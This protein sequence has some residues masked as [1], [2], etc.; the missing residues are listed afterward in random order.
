MMKHP[1][2][3]A[4]LL[5]SVARTI[6]L[7]GLGIGHLARAANLPSAWQRAQQFEVAAPG[8]VKLSLPIETL[9]ASRPGLEDLRLHDDAGTELPYWIQIPAPAPQVIQR[10]KGFQ[11]ALNPTSTTVT[12]ETGLAQAIDGVLLESPSTDFIKSVRV[13]SSSDG[14]SWQPLAQGVPIFRQ[15]RGANQ[16]Q[17]PIP[18]GIRPWLRLTVDDQRS[19]PIP[20][21]GASLHAA[22]G[23]PAPSEVLPITLSERHENPGESRLTLNLGAGNA[24][25]ASIQIE[26][27]DPLFIRRVTL[28]VSEVLEDSVRETSL[29]RGVIYRV[30]VEGQAAAEELSIPLEKQVRS[31]QLLVLIDNQDSPPLSITRVRAL[32][33]P[34]YLIFQAR[35][36]GV[37]HLVTGNP[38]CPPARYDLAALGGNL[39]ATALSSIRF[40]AVTTNSSFHPPEALPGVQSEGST[41]DVAA[42]RFRKAVKL[43]RIGAQQ[44]EMDLDVLSHAQTDFQ[45]VRLLKDGKQWPYILERTSIN[46]KLTPSIS[47]ARDVK[48]PK[49]SRWRIKLSHGALPITRLSC[50]SRTPLFQRDVSIYEEVADRRGEKYRRI[51]GSATW[52]QT[53]D[54]QGRELVV[55]LGARLETDTL[56]L[57]THDGDNPAIELEGFQ[58][59]YSAMRILFKTGSEDNLFLYYGNPRVPSPR[60]DLNLVAVQLLGSDKSVASLASE[61]PLKKARWGDGGTA[62]KGGVVF[63]GALAVVVVALLV[64][65]SRLLPSSPPPAG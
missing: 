56:F 64:I 62:G 7:I 3:R 10:A 35:T 44:I 22:Q 18:L 61:E 27:P 31:R 24:S 28:A 15:P 59:F 57:E 53:P 20:F 21:T 14:T 26:T 50:R 11:I 43:T 52:V 34:V 1:H 51:A 48:N 6:C 12:L 55:A 38:Q 32:R 13:E 4:E 29:A 39:K 23:E 54:K 36:G 46:R 41:L 65:I 5:V 45:D 2:K 47:Y 25:L 9:D 42:W 40:S 63:W 16:L 33:R 8:L 58:L 30:A 60:Y 17:V 19:Q 37:H 49:L